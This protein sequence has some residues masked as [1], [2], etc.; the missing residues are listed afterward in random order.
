MKFEKLFEPIKIG[1]V[2]IPNRIAL[3]PMNIH[4]S[5]NGGYTGDEYTCFCNARA[6]GGGELLAIAGP[7]KLTWGVD[8]SGSLAGHKK[9]VEYLETIQI[10][11]ELQRDYHYPP[12]TEETRRKWAGLNMAKILKIDVPPSS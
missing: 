6:R 2:E 5:E 3:I 8:W 4:F 10:S 1:P 11:E 9:A 7:D 12:I